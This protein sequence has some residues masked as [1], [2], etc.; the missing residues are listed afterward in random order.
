MCLH[1]GYGKPL[2]SEQFSLQEV[3]VR[4]LR[5]QNLP[6]ILAFLAILKI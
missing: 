1:N 4:K 5:E 6:Y 2:T 3:E